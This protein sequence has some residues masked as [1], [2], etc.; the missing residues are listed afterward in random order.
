M[1]ARALPK[2]TE[3]NNSTT[4]IVSALPAKTVQANTTTTTIVAATAQQPQI[5]T[6]TQPQSITTAT[7]HQQHSVVSAVGLETM[8]HQPVSVSAGN[9]NHLDKIVFPLSPVNVEIMEHT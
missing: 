4:T 1:V 2:K 9:S 7:T 8:A 3:N 6:S 5:A